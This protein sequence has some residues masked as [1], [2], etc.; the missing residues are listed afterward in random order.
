MLRQTADN[1]L[2]KWVLGGGSNILLTA[3]VPALIIKSEI[4][5]VNIEKADKNHVYIK[6]GSG[7]KWHFLVETAVD[8]QMGGIENLSLIPGTVG[9]APIQNIGAYGAELKD[10]FHSLTALRLSDAKAVT[11][12]E[13]ECRFGYRDSIFKHEAKGKYLITSVTLR[14]NRNPVLNTAYGSLTEILKERGEAPSLQ[15]IFDAVVAIRRSKLPDPAEI[16]NA[17]SFFKNPEIP[18]A[19]Y[20]ALKDTYPEIPLFPAAAP[21]LVKVPAGWLIEQ[22]GWKGK[23]IGNCGVHARQALVLVNY[24]GATGAEIKQLAT[25]VQQTV[26]E[27]FGIDLSTEVNFIPE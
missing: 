26:L 15:S 22:C 13:A 11:F 7:V 8:L 1:P 4:L 19:H 18:E 10:V 27:K 23:R 17:G 6:A 3:D 16:G 25:D 9:A 12:K 2:P 5:G 24:G 20:Q 21:G 14:L